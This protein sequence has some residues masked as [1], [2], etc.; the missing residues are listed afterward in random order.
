MKSLVNKKSI[1]EFECKVKGHIPDEEDLQELVDN[2]KF[3]INTIC[4]RCG[5][6]VRIEMDPN[7]SNNYIITE[8]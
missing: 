1:M 7:N 6:E 2:P 5:V 4:D 8:Q 3:A